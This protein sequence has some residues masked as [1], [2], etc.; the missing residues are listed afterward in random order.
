MVRRQVS[1]ALFS[2]PGYRPGLV[3]F[4]MRRLANHLY[5]GGKFQKK[6][7]SQAKAQESL[8]PK[9]CKEILAES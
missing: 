4:L 6:K 7:T 2:L 5:S 3:R 8:L 1:D 9:K